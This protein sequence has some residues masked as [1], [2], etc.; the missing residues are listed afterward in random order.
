MV[1]FRQK[2]LRRLA[3]QPEGSRQRADDDKN[4]D[5]RH[6]REAAHD[7]HIAVADMVDAAQHIA[8]GTAASLAVLEQHRAKRRAQGE[9]VE[10]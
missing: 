5:D 2:T 3:E 7:R 6:A 1:L 10:R 9:R 8:H 4:A